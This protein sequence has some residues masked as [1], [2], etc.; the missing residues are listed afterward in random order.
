LS[1]FVTELSEVKSPI[2]IGGNPRSGT[3]FTAALLEAHGRIVVT[4]EINPEAAELA[5]QMMRRLTVY[6]GRTASRKR[7]WQRNRAQLMTQIWKGVTSRLLIEA[8][9]SSSTIAHKTPGSEQRFEDYVEIFAPIR[10]KLVYCLRDGVSVM[11]SLTNMPWREVSFDRR[12]ALYNESVALYEHLQ[13]KYPQDVF[14]FQVDKAPIDS[15]ARLGQI[16]ELFDFIGEPIDAPTEAFVAQW[17]L[18]N[19]MATVIGDDRAVELQADHL[20]TLAKDEAFVAA[21]RRYGYDALLPHVPAPWQRI[22]WHGLRFRALGEE[23]GAWPLAHHDQRVRIH[24]R[25]EDSIRVRVALDEGE[26][27]YLTSG[28]GRATGAADPQTCDRSPVRL[29]RSYGCCNTTTA[30]ASPTRECA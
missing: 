23:R 26:K 3:T 15:A 19:T 17:P 8:K 20:R 2:I 10:P 29:Q 13:R 18:R 5:C 25:S 16:S 12:V 4:S 28:G 24:R 14:L 30:P 21:Q 22:E 27:V 11:R 9:P 6:M 7:V 1:A